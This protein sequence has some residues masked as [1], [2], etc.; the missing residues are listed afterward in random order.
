MK[1]MKEQAISSGP[2]NV[3]SSVSAK[4]GDVMGAFAPG[5]LPRGEMQV[6]FSIFSQPG[7][8]ALRNDATV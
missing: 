3:V 8:W 7:R 4:I 2:N 1:Q 6:F 5:Q